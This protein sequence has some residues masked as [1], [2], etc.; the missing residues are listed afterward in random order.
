[1]ETAIS[2]EQQAI[3]LGPRDPYIGNFYARIGQAHLLLAYTD[4]AIIWFE[5]A[6]GAI[7]GYGVPHAWLASAYALKGETER[8]AFELAKA[9]KLTSRYSS[10]ARVKAAGTLGGPGYWGV[11]KVRALF[12]ATYFTGLRKAGMPEG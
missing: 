10:I 7:P 6:A 9:R 2:L 8:A 11:P 4:E 1:M 3:R 5:K 12:E